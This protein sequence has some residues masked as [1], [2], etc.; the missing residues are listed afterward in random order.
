ML[1]DDAR[2]RWSEV[3]NAVGVEPR[4]LVNR[5]GPCPI[6]G[7]RDRFRYDN[8]NGDGTYFCNQCG[9]G[10]GWTL[11]RKVKGWDAK[12]AAEEIERI[13]GSRRNVGPVHIKPQASNAQRAEAIQALMREAVYPGVVSAYLSR[14]GITVGSP[15]LRGHARCPYFEERRR[16]GYY[17]AVIAPIVDE[18]GAIQ[19]AHRIYDADVPERKKMMPPITT[20][21]GCAVRLFDADETLGIAEGI[22]TA[23]AAHELF[24]V[25]TWATLTAGGMQ[26]LPLPLGVNRLV[27]YAD[28]DESMTGQLAAYNLA[29]RAAM[30]G[31]G[32]EVQIPP[33]VGEDWLDVLVE[34]ERG[35]VEL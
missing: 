28:N 31:V 15:V 32:V 27:I 5:H 26:A 30:A 25:P 16:T 21:Q 12:T 11:V 2:G 34:R 22:E 20:V 17:P 18:K 19:S 1:S 13:L 10:N 35:G 24:G 33:R 9:A 14:R 7:G 8:K 23:L 4:F 6:C 29:K 3:L